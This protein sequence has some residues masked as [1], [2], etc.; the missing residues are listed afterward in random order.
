MDLDGFTSFH[1]VGTPIPQPILQYIFKRPVQ[2]LKQPAAPPP[3]VPF[4]LHAQNLSYVID[5]LQP[6]IGYK[7]TN[8]YFYWIGCE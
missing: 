6:T 2:P 8:C 1:L 5:D 3:P 7:G 4:K